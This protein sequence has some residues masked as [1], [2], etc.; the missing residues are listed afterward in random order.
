MP[1]AG[2]VILSFLGLGSVE[3]LHPAVLGHHIL[4]ILDDLFILLLHQQLILR[5]HIEQHEDLRRETD[6]IGFVLGQKK[7]TRIVW[8]APT[9]V[10]PSRFIILLEDLPLKAELVLTLNLPTLRGWISQVYQPEKRNI[11]EREALL[12]L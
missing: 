11:V 10:I 6:L 7:T 3:R 8:S 12:S 2:A 4:D 1:H 5:H 9:P